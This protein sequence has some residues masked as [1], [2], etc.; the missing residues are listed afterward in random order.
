MKSKSSEDPDLFYDPNVPFHH[1]KKEAICVYHALIRQA[2]ADL[3]TCMQRTDKN[4]GKDAIKAL[5]SAQ[6]SVIAA[7]IAGQAME[8]RLRKYR[9]AIE[10][11]GFKRTNTK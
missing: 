1:K 5:R 7:T 2:L 3:E 4:A 9:T 11:L 8:D 10:H 6:K